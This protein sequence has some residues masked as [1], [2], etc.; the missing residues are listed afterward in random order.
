MMCGGR[1]TRLEKTAEK[2]L[3][4]LGG[5]AMVDRVVDAL[6]ESRIETIHAVVSPHTPN[7]HD[8]LL[9]NEAITCISAP[10]EGYV[11]DLQYALDRVKRPALTV[12]ADLPLITDTVVDGVLDAASTNE[13]STTVCVP[14]I[15]KEIIGASVDTA[16][17]DDNRR[18]A[19]T[20]VNVVGNAESDTIHMSYDIRLAINV[21]RPSDTDL[22][23]ALL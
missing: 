13:D 14:A 5:R 12:A 22:A 19:P 15:L 21:N 17:D 3:V 10:G 23:E 7:T 2:P 11:P 1:G 8:H 4:E 16:F 9:T 18:V 20:G 6:S